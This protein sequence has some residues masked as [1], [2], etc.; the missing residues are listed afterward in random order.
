MGFDDLM[1][2]AA[3]VKA[4]LLAE[5]EEDEDPEEGAGPRMAST[6]AH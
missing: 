3:V 5:L 2:V 1:R 4:A 6:N